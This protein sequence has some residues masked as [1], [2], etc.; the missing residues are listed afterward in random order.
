MLREQ[1]QVDRE[2]PPQEEAHVEAVPAVQRAEEEEEVV[3]VA[4]LVE[5][6]L[7]GE[8]VTDAGS[9]SV[10]EGGSEAERG[11]R[12]E[13]GYAGVQLDWSGGS[14]HL[15]GCREL[16]VQILDVQNEI[17]HLTRCTKRAVCRQSNKG[18]RVEYERVGRAR[19]QSAWAERVGRARG[20]GRFREALS[21]Q[22]ARRSRPFRQSASR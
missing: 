21:P 18:E 10:E 22:G 15:K 12:S 6:N 16:E 2:A 3:V 19:E 8:E 11:R 14:T 20:G 13:E 7:L 17:G 9:G 5:E 4:Q 1:Q